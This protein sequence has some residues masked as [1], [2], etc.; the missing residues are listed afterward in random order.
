MS[1][2]RQGTLVVCLILGVFLSCKKAEEK[3]RV[4]LQNQASKAYTFTVSAGGQTATQ[5]VEAGKSWELPQTIT[6]PQEWITVNVADT[7]GFCYQVQNAKTLLFNDDGGAYVLNCEAGD[8]PGGCNPQQC[9]VTPPP[10]PPPSGQTVTLENQGGAA[11]E[12]TVTQGTNTATQKVEAKASWQI[13]FTVSDNTWFSVNVP[14]IG[15]CYQAQNAGE[16]EFADEGVYVLNCQPGKGGGGCD[17]QPCPPS[18]TTAAP[19]A[20]PAAATATPGT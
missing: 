6:S 3:Q 9:P 10:P 8:G 2:K 1:T 17:T 18:T 19:V 15:F 5:T 7:G 14:N 11:Y 4:T 12:F 16:V 20:A 13:P